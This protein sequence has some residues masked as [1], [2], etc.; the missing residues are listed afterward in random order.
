M[1]KYLITLATGLSLFSTLQAQ[2]LTD[3]TNASRHQLADM[4]TRKSRTGKWVGFALLGGGAICSVLGAKEAGQSGGKSAL[5]TI[6]LGA[7][8]ISNPI[9]CKSA[10]NA[11][12]AEILLQEPIDEERRKV[13]IK[14]YRKRATTGSLA[15]WG[16]FLGG[17]AGLFVSAGQDS[18]SMLWLSI[19]AMGAS[20]PIWTH[21]AKNKGRLMI[22]TG[23]EHMP[24]N[25]AGASSYRKLG[26]GIPIGR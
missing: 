24:A 10:R 5:L 23:T 26:I 16:V 8:A 22:L 17:F 19:A 7:M 20:L 9:L 11:G 25:P 14:D 6:G 1:K 3:S 15:A 4:Y 13:L 12:K 2:R 21:A 18:E